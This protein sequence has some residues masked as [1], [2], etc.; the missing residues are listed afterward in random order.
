MTKTTE[1]LMIWGSLGAGVALMLSGHRRL[2]FLVALTAPVTTTIQ[3]PR[4]TW[5]TLKGAPKGV[6][7]AGKAA[8]K[9]GY[10]AGRAVGRMVS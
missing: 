1:N 7:M 10:V 8:G 4:A 6:Y 5:A 2:G 3:H 9:A